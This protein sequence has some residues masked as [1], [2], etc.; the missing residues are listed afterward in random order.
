MG[1][2]A[3]PG[4][5][6]KAGPFY[7]ELKMKNATVTL[8]RRSGQT[9]Q[10]RNNAADDYRMNQMLQRGWIPSGELCCRLGI[11]LIGGE[12]AELRIVEV[13]SG[14]GKMTRLSTAQQKMLLRLS[15]A[16]NGVESQPHTGSRQS[17]RDLSGW[18]RTVDS[19]QRAG[20]V[21]KERSGGNTFRV[22]LLKE[23][24]SP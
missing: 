19:L 10:V 7:S 21:V 2:S 13:S 22:R 20:L 5:G 18:H 23:T 6:G 4:V 9:I 14:D 24:V 11:P 17:V 15:T 8:E 1:V 12:T 16:E 3:N